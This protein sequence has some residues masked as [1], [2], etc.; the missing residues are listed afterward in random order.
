M[1]TRRSDWIWYLFYANCSKVYI[2]FLYSGEHGAAYEI[3]R[4][5]LSPKEQ[6]EYDVGWKNN[7]FNQFASDRISVRRRLPDYREG[8]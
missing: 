5:F 6:E 7:A 3:E 4:L 2:L 8:T 1:V